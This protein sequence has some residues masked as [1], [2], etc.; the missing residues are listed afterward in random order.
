MKI[1]IAPLLLLSLTACKKEEKKPGPPSAPSLTPGPAPTPGGAAGS[2]PTPGGAAGSAAAPAPTGCAT[3]RVTLAKDKLTHARGDTVEL[4]LAGGALDLTA[5]TTALAT[6]A[7]ECVGPL[8]VSATDDVV[9][10]DIVMIMDKALTAGFTDIALDDPGASGDAA[11]AP[12]GTA[13]AGATATDLKA[14]PIVTISPGR[15]AVS[16]TELP[17]GTDVTAGLTAAL[18]KAKAGGAPTR[19][20]ILQADE[21]TR[22]A[23]I[24]AVVRAAHQAGFDDVLFAVK[25]AP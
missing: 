10:R 21:S 23:E 1:A 12:A 24:N 18:E 4:A 19:A 16:G 9:Y 22:G 2:A 20:V 17:A 13:P 6:R 8:V 25:R 7:K 5:L 3:L 14:A 15:I 11:T